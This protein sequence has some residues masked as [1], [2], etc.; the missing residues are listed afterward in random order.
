MCFSSGNMCRGRWMI[1]W[2]V[3]LVINE[4]MNYCSVLVCEFCVGECVGVFKSWYA[5]LRKLS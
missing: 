2:G 1:D 5:E 4:A 3:V